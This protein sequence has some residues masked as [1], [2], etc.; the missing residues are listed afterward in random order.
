MNVAA[1]AVP[2]AKCATARLEPT[3]PFHFQGTVHKPSHFPAPVST[4]QRG[5]YWQ[6][7]RL[8]ADLLRG[9]MEGGCDGDR[10]AIDVTLYSPSP[11]S[12][13]RT[14][15]ALAE[16]SWRFD[17]DCDLAPFDLASRDDPLLAPVVQRWSGMRVSAGCSLYETLIIFIT[18]QNATVRRTVQMM[19]ALL[20]TYGTPL[21]FDGHT[22]YA[23]WKPEDM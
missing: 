2:L 1:R 6:A 10:P 3:P 19:Q 8:R 22:L 16:L 18:L 4:Y 17:L 21:E 23:F 11:L 5:V 13:A 9:R 12:R 14:A 15:A 20:S 7:L